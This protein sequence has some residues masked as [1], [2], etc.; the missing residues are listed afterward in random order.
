MRVAVS[1]LGRQRSVVHLLIICLGKSAMDRIATAV[2]STDPILKAGLCSLLGS[3]P[4]LR[5]VR[6][7]QD[8]CTVMIV[9]EDAV[10]A[11]II[12]AIQQAR[13][14]SP[15]S[16]RLTTLVISGT[17][18]AQFLMPAVEAGVV[19]VLP[20]NTT[21]TAV[22]DA[23]V[24]V[25]RGAARFTPELQAALITN[26]DRIRVDI[27]EPNNL[28]TTGLAERE[29]EVIR[30]I[31]QGFD[32]AEIATV[33]CYSERTIKNILHGVMSRLHLQNR[34]QAVAYA[35]RAG[36]ICLPKQKRTARMHALKCPYDS[37]SRRVRPL[38]CTPKA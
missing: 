24:D 30:L 21:A 26:L 34:A 13:A 29:R 14:S 3:H 1:W 33:M 2:R 22:V 20:R 25:A 38:S 18:P 28:T 6:D 19:S 9:I 12:R 4:S 8:E 35:I 27:L 36:A 11:E 17:F 5:I 16:R 23:V 32:T 10:T 37:V 15:A 31:A 7:D